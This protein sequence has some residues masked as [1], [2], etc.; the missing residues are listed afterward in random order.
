MFYISVIVSLTDYV[1]TVLVRFS[2]YHVMPLERI[3]NETM[4]IILGYPKTPKIELLQVE[5]VHPSVVCQIHEIACRALC[6][7]VRQGAVQP[8]HVLLLCLLTLGQ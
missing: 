4:R 1:P 7:V 6:R 8:L 2:E 5:L 3:Q